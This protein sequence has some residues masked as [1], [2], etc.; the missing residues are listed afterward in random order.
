MNFWRSYMQTS[1][2]FTSRG[3]GRMLFA[4]EQNEFHFD[5][6]RPNQN[7]DVQNEQILGVVAQT[8]I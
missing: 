1:E 3:A 2:A 7:I 4:Q 6:H 5:S 8:K